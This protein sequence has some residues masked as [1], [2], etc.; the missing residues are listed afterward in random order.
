MADLIDRQELRRA[1]YHEAFDKDTKDQ[2]WDSGCWIRYRMFERII[3]SIPSAQPDVLACGT[4]ELNV[5]DTN[6]GDMISRQAAITLPVTPK[7]HREYQTFNLDDAYEQGWDDLQKCIESL[8][9]AQRTGR[10]Y[11]DAEGNV[12]C[13]VCKTKCLRDDI[14]INILSNYCPSCGAKME[15][16]R[17]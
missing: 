17:K 5:L 16:E 13:T 2:R 14:G 4:G 6:V 15:G 7:E 8:P 11:I 12:R 1:M 10:W 9:S 3:D